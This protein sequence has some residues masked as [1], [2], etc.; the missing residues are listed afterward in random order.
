MEVFLL[1]LLSR[2]LE[3][4]EAVNAF[5]LEV[6][7]LCIQMV[8]QDIRELHNILSRILT[9]SLPIYIGT[10][11]SQKAKKSDREKTRLARTNEA[12]RKALDT[13]CCLSRYPSYPQ[14]TRSQLIGKDALVFSSA[15]VRIV[16]LCSLS[17]RVLTLG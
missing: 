10:E 12:I 6:M 17:R 3:G 2:D 16:P 1:T 9:P 15:V 13:V 7:D 4:D 8:P 5:I 14:L 11:E